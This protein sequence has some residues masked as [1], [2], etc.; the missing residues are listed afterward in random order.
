MNKIKLILAIFS[1]V[2]VGC[3]DDT[4]SSGNNDSTE[5]ISGTYTLSSVVVHGS[6]DCSDQ[7]GV[8]GTCFPEPQLSE[9]ECPAG[10]CNCSSDLPEV[11]TE[12]D[13]DAV[14]GDWDGSDCTVQC[15]ATTEAECLAFENS[16][17]DSGEWYTGGFCMNINTGDGMSCGESNC[18]PSDCADDDEVSWINIGWNLWAAVLPQIS[19]TFSND[20]TYSDSDNGTGTWT[21]EGAVLTMVNSDNEVTTGTVSGSTFTTEDMDGVFGSDPVCSVMTFSK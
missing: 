6:G 20:G 11:T 7:N 4:V 21:Q 3:D 19:V 14:D 17:G 13:C 2:M 10:N 18:Q 9:A 1:L 12:E 5:S 16:D 15:G 8:S